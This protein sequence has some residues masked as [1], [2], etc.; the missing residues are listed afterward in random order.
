MCEKFP[1]LK[2]KAEEA[3]AVTNLEEEG[4]AV[5]RRASAE[6][7]GEVHTEGG[8]VD[9]EAGGGEAEILVPEG[10]RQTKKIQ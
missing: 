8:G 9:G 1:S 6:E 7:E 2:Q 5:I 3:V 10:V 4:D